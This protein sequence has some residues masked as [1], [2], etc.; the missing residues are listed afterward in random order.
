[1]L[2][3]PDWSTGGYVSGYNGITQSSFNTTSSSGD[4]TTF[5]HRF[6][7]NRTTSAHPDTVIKD[8]F[9]WEDESQT[10]AS[11][12]V[13]QAITNGKLASG[14]KVQDIYT[15]G[16][17]WSVN[18]AAGTYDLVVY[19]DFNNDGN[20]AKSEMIF[21]INE[22]NGHEM[23]DPTWG[24]T[25]TS[26]SSKG[27]DAAIWNQYAYM[28]IDNAFYTSNPNRSNKSNEVGVTLFTDLLTQESGDKTTFDLEY[29]RVYQEDGR[30]DIVTNETEAFNTGN[31]YGY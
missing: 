21:H 29:V 20:M 18:E 16:Y 23:N 14:S 11:Y 1:M 5:I 17:W 15:Y 6:D 22:T 25:P 24:N 28:L 4:N 13:A 7:P 9:F 8:Y 26:S 31:R 30:R 12:S 3:L 10:P 2:Y 19:V 27:K